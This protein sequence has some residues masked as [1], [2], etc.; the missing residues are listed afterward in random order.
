MR[1]VKFRAWNKK[2]K[3]MSDSFDLISLMADNALDRKPEDIIEDYI[4][5]QFTGLKDRNGVEIYEGDII[6]WPQKTK[7]LWSDQ[8]GNEEV[9]WP[10]I[11]GNAYLGEII[12]NVYENPELIKKG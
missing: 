3:T 8:K 2:R 5:Q 6:R 11:C 9:K 4:I 7:G 12:G 10:F 1:E